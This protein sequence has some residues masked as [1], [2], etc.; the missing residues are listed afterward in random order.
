MAS[1]AVLICPKAFFE[2]RSARMACF[3]PAVFAEPAAL[4]SPGATDHSVVHLLSDLQIGGKQR[5]A[6]RL[7]ERGLAAGGRHELWLFDRPFRSRELDFDP[8]AVPVHFLPRGP[9]L[10]LCFLRR[11]VCRLAA[12]GVQAVHA[13]DD[14][15][16]YYAA[17]ACALLGRRAPR[18]VGTFHTWPGYG[19]RAVRFLAR[20]ACGQV[21]AVVAVSDELARRLVEQ[22]WLKRCR[23]VWNGIDLDLFRPGSDD[24]SWHRRLGLAS[25]ALLVVHIARFHRVKR[26]ADLVEAARLVHRARPGVAFI[27]AGRGPTRAATQELARDLGCVHFVP[28]VTDVAALLRAASVFV[29]PSEHEAAPLAL[30]EAMACS[31]AC[32]CT[33]VG[34]MP[35]MLA[36]GSGAPCGALVSL[37]DPAALAA[38]ITKLLS[39]PGLRADVGCRA[40]AAAA[41]FSFAREW[42]AYH[43]LY[44]GETP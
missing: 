38:S 11:L 35:A 33:A 26:H 42:G 1:Y 18:V 14:I 10:D 32:V 13:H 40:R 41:R 31:C 27:L 12:G 5:A 20:W 9:G 3:P 44:A 21:D 15:A 28:H 19:T 34:G 4:P 30:L 8:G 39:D 24:G 6:L 29:L 17:L 37:G 22:G 7:A 36:D 23:T 16:V 43:R 25:D 2:D